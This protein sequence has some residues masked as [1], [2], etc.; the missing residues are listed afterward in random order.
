MGNSVWLT[1]DGFEGLAFESVPD[2]VEEDAL[3]A[4]DVWNKYKHIFLSFFLI[5]EKVKIY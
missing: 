4:S 1:P 3:P 5:N 2:E